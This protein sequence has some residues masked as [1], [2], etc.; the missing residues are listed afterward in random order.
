MQEKPKILTSFFKYNIIA[1]LATGIDFIVFI[2]LTET[3][4]LWY[5]KSTVISAII[6]G[7]AAFIMNRNWVFLSKGG[8]LSKQAIKYLIV[9]VSSIFLNAAGL[10]LIV[11]STNINEII[12]KIIVS[13]L[14]GV[15]YNF[16]MY[17]F[18]VFK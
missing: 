3:F 13:I 12:S 16:L 11:E 18:F 7:I 6:G 2:L 17:K 15:G 1:V 5:V 14:V 8:Q 4:D 9:W 10:F